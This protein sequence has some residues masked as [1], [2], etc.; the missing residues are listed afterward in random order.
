MSFLFPAM[1][2]GLAGLAIPVVIHLIAR[3]RYQVQEFPSLRLLEPDERSNVF[4]MRLVDAGQL[5]LRL[6]VLLLLVL[7]MSRLFAPWLPWGKAPRNL[8]V[9]VD[10]S[11]SMRMLRKDPESGTTAPLIDLAKAKAREL[12]EGIG[13]PSQC[14]LLAAGE[15]AELRAPL[16]PEPRHALRA[17]EELTTVDGAGRG[18][19]HAVGRCCELVSG[20]REAR[21]QIVVLTD[22]CA[23]AF[24]ARN[25]ED[26][27]RI[28][29]ARKQRG[30][31][32]EILFVDVS[33]GRTENV[34]LRRAL[35]RGPRVKVGD[36]AH[37]VARVIN[38]GD[39]GKTA[40]L[41]LAVGKRREPLVRE[42][43]L[44]PGGEADVDLTLPVNRAVRTFVEVGV[45]PDDALPHDNVLSVP[46][47]VSDARRVLIVDGTPEP[48]GGTP[49][50]PLG[51]AGAAPSP[52]GQP[53]QDTG[54]GEPAAGESLSGAK[55]LRL[56]LNPGRE[57]GRAHG[58]GIRT[59]VVTPEA[60]KGQPLSKYDVVAL[61]DVSALPQQALRDLA[62]FVRQG[63]SLLLVCS[64]GISAMKFNRTF[65]SAEAGRG[66][67]S[68]A[69]LGN[70]R[71]LDPPVGISF[72]D[73]AHP[74]LA[75]F[76]DR[77][78]GD[79]SAVRFAATRELRTLA[80]GATVAFSGTDGQPL[81]A[82]MA[83][84]RGRVL[85]LA[86][87]FELERGNIARTRVFPV[88][89]W[90]LV[91]YLTGELE[92]AP[93]DLLTASRPAVL[94]V[95]EPPFA[96]LGELELCPVDAA[97]G[98][99]TATR[100]PVSEARTVLL[101]GLP[102]GRYL[103]RKPEEPG[104]PA[105][106]TTYA[107]HIAVN[108]D[109]RESRTERLDEAELAKLF[110]EGVRV[111]SHAE[112]ADLSLA[113]GELWLLLVGLLVLAYIAEGGVGWVLSARREKTRTAGADE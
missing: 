78:R 77:L 56:V 112:P 69:P 5:L 59:T 48:S 66:V 19:V 83:V 42:V 22:L 28:Q 73:S 38:S 96:F 91:D 18:L 8:V 88:L 101:G 1:L 65:A 75:P 84:G 80:P 64:G 2:A 39:K 15:A 108:P 54:D 37:V 33:S 51:S 43:T 86:F 24:E 61:Y 29:E 94:D 26:L 107:R 68:P 6:L 111:R 67:L 81:A 12:L 10:C 50:L 40:R 99:A 89:A 82:E 46:L 57:L 85:L 45:E 100:L 7:A 20:R 79:L 98:Q 110:G 97:P 70:E 87:G 72:A 17:L 49:L 36:D 3:H 55:I 109:P 11:A 4:A 41:R 25:Q 13:P 34:A 35:V 71:A 60:L 9:V 47:N 44:G 93:P 74:L 23:S 63:R 27:Q 113:G 92:P 105:R 102:A 21:S 31:S 30:S 106:R 32:L 53:D 103:L 14:A 76:R 104:G 58:T 16:R 95:S 52:L 90:E 62:T